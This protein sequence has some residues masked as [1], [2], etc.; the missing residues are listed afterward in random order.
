MVAKMVAVKKD[1][2]RDFV[3]SWERYDNNGEWA[4][5]HVSVWQRRLRD[6]GYHEVPTAQLMGV[7]GWT[8]IHEW[9]LQKFGEDHYTWTGS[10]FWFETEQHAVLF[11]LRWA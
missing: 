11:T 8:D 9:C 2:I 3:Q 1:S 5:P 10:I 7:T 4:V 6:A